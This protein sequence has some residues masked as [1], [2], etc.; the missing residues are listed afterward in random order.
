MALELSLQD[1]VSIQQ[2]FTRQKWDIDENNKYSL[3]NRFIHTYRR[4]T[5]V[6]RSL[7]ISLS[8]HFKI[9]TLDQYQKQLVDVLSRIVQK[10]LGKKQTIYVYPIKKKSHAEHIKSADVVTYLCNATQMKYTDVLSN[11]NVILFG[12]MGQVEA[13]KPQIQKNVLIIVDDFIGSGKYTTEVVKELIS[14]G[15]SPEQIVIASLYI[16]QAGIEKLR[17]TQCLLEYGEIIEAYIE[18]LTPPEKATLAEIEKKMC[19]DPEFQFGFGH[20]GTLVS[21]IRTPNNTLPIFWMP[22][23]RKP[24]PPFPR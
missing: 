13:K 18:K 24:A 16:T 4:L 5:D 14:L 19:V 15:L 12:S 17:N 7:L 6:E 3:Y 8:Y 10:Y 9:V 23:G 11:K 2:L 20:S 21:L 22:V 1:M